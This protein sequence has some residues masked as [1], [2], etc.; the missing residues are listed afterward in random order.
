MTGDAES[1]GVLQPGRNC[2]RIAR[3]DR[4]VV[5]VDAADYYHVAREAMLKARHNI[6]L[7]GWDFDTRITLERSAEGKDRGETVGNFFLRL[8]RENPDVRINILNWNIGALKLLFRGSAL[9][10]LLR[11]KLQRQIYFRLDSAHP[12]GCSHHQKIL[13]IDDA[14]AVCGGI[15]MTR[16]RWDTNEHCDDD[17]RRHEPSGKLYGPW[18]DATMAMD[19]AAAK[20]LGDLGRKRWKVA[21]GEELAPPPS[22]SDPWPSDL[23]PTF[24]GVDV[25]LSRTRAE[26]K[27]LREVSEIEAL[28]I[29]LIAGAKRFIYSENQYFTS[30][31]IA[32]AIAARMA[33]PDAPEIVQIGPVK[34]D[35]WLEQQAM[36]GARIQIARAMDAIS[37]E[38]KFRIYTPVT[39]GGADI[40]VHAK[41]MIV[42]DMIL[43]VGS[44]N[45]NN[46]S[47]G[48]DSECD[49]LIDAHDNPEASPAIAAL[50]NRLLAEHLD[51]SP[52]EFADHFA[53][54]GSLIASIEILRGKAKTL[55][56]LPL[57]HLGE[58]QEFI[59]ENELLDPES[60]D[61]FFE[62]LSQRSLLRGW[63]RRTAKRIL[64]R[65]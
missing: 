1:K 46:R 38:R 18:H 28:Y 62:P 6:L 42:D 10:T 63:G 23:L 57:E 17:P 32:A 50:R 24:K 31:K 35:G 26:H 9:F 41:V 52:E 3:A 39:K 27:E 15:D 56:P 5:I 37:K 64:R 14:F 53:K 48:L 36:D 22:G 65:R 7:I 33:G 8:V 40:Y 13:V 34:A 12:P 16:D 47:L 60:A 45:W 43:R 58:M 30:R 51:V 59:A 25:G 54:S 19:G 29:D 11:W 44:S 2:W 49:A 55:K 20:S 4:A 21:T 61:G